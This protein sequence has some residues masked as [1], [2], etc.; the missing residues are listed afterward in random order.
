MQ[1]LDRGPSVLPT[2]GSV[3][4]MESLRWVAAS[5]TV[6]PERCT[7]TIDNSFIAM[8]LQ[9]A[10]YSTMLGI[11]T[12]SKHVLH[13][14]HLLRNTHKGAICFRGPERKV[15]IARYQ[16]SLFT[17]RIIARIALFGCFRAFTKPWRHA[18]YESFGR[19][20]GDGKVREREL[21]RR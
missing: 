12:L 7:A 9:D 21:E 18:A 3:Q 11:C 6:L 10:T 13:K 4:T 8:A 5:A 17:T 1:C 14:A 15:F 19:Y 20:G 16:K 2:Q